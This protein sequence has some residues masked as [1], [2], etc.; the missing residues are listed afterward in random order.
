MAFIKKKDHPRRKRNRRLRN[1]ENPHE[2]DEIIKEKLYL[3]RL[4]FKFDPSLSW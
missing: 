3:G 2:I 4:P 1:M